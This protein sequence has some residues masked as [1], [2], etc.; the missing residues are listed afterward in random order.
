[1]RIMTASVLAMLVGSGSVYAAPSASEAEH[2]VGWYASH[3]TDDL[4]VMHECQNDR[5]FE[6]YPDCKNA[7][8]ADDLF[9][10][11]ER[12]G[13]ASPDKLALFASG[14]L[15]AAELASCRLSNPRIRPPKSD[16]NAAQQVQDNIDKKKS[17][18][19]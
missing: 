14:P 2:T 4:K 3:R 8:A 12:Q 5:T 16:C 10:A 13:G 6:A 7:A 11:K 17:G 9:T 18:T 15:R 19:K 1:M